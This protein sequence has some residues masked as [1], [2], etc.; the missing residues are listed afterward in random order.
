MDGH[1]YRNVHVAIV[2]HRTN[3][4]QITSKKVSGYTQQEEELCIDVLTHVQEL[5][6]LHTVVISEGLGSPPVKP[7]APKVSRFQ[8][9]GQD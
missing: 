2:H 5:V 6:G 8:T 7:W 1:C 3:S 4:G 9:S